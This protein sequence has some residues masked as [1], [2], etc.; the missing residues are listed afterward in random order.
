[1]RRKLSKE[2]ILLGPCFDAADAPGNLYDV[3]KARLLHFNIHGDRVVFVLQATDRPPP[4]GWSFP[5]DDDGLEESVQAQ[6]VKCFDQ[7]M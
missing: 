6:F 5:P 7:E 3:I 4:V 2:D 1:M